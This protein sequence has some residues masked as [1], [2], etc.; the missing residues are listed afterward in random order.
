LKGCGERRKPVLL[1]Y[2]KK[3]LCT[4]A[5]TAMRGGKKKRPDLLP[6]RIRPAA[7]L[8]Q[9]EM[10]KIAPGKGSSCDERNAALGSGKSARKWQ[11]E[12]KRETLVTR[13][14][15]YRGV[16]NQYRPVAAEKT[17]GWLLRASSG[18]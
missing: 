8:R 5:V 18:D 2:K 13:G 11:E 10:G 15:G 17:L 16:R 9:K 14:P 12:K 6:G 7:H 3:P 4:K 1:N